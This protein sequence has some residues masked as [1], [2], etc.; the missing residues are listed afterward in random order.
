MHR[1]IIDSINSTIDKLAYLDY[2]PQPAI[3]LL[4][5]LLVC[6]VYNSPFC[7][8][9]FQFFKVQIELKKKSFVPEL[10]YV[11][12]LIFNHFFNKNV[13]HIIRNWVFLGR[14]VGSALSREIY[15]GQIFHFLEDAA[16]WPIIKKCKWTML[17][18]AILSLAQW[19]SGIVPTPTHFPWVISCA[20]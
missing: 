2:C 4:D 8:T 18:Q 9:Y 5:L 12:I 11:F 7:F 19:A 3:P 1:E 6:L 13:N 16:K 10:D 17:A 14:I 20:I 15:L